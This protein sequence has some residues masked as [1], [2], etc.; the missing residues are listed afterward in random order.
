MRY[1]YPI[2]SREIKDKI[3]EI[4]DMQLYI[5]GYTDPSGLVN[6]SGICQNIDASGIVIFSSGIDQFAT[7]NPYFGKTNYIINNIHKRS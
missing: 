4:Y 5:L 6:Y 2:S 1:N 7:Y 3:D